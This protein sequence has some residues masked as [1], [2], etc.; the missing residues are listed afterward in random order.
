MTIKSFIEKA[1]EGGWRNPRGYVDSQFII[2]MDEVP[3]I[4]LD[5]LAWKA[6]GKVDGWKPIS[7]CDYCGGS[8]RCP[9]APEPCAFCEGTGTDQ[10]ITWLSQM[11]RMIDT[12]ADGK[13]IEQY[14][15]TL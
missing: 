9:D 4:L 7:E 8:G 6:V 3:H 13:T 10:S 1:I 2:D 15:E 5:P 14:L 11:H 12:L